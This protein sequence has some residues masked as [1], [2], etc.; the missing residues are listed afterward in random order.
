MQRCHFW[1]FFAVNRFN[2]CRLH[3]GDDQQV[4]KKPHSRFFEYSQIGQFRNKTKDINPLKKSGVIRCM[5]V[6]GHT[7]QPGMQGHSGFDSI[8]WQTN[9]LENV[10]HV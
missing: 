7:S 5:S 1:A 2:D 8:T 9:V 3:L 10:E 6:A 4:F